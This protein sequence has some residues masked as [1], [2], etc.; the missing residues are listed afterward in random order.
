MPAIVSQLSDLSDACELGP[1]DF[2]PQVLV[3]PP[4]TWQ[5]AWDGRCQLGALLD[6]NLVESH[7]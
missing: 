6:Q 3:G 4:C 1:C 5:V 7:K 2:L